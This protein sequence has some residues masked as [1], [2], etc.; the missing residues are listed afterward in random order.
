MVRGL[1]PCLLAASLAAAPLRAGASPG[2]QAEGECDRWAAI[3]AAEFGV[4]ER[5]LLA[6]TR[7]ETGRAGA[8]GVVAP[9]PWTV[10]AG[11]EGHWF[12]SARAAADFVRSAVARGE[13]QVDVG[14]FQLNTGW[15]GRAFASA[16]QMIEPSRN[17]RY[18][19]RFLANLHAEFGTWTQAAA[20][21]HSRT[22]HLGR[23]YLAKVSAALGEMG[24]A[25][26]NAPGRIQPLVAGA[27]ADAPP[28]VAPGAV[29]AAPGGVALGGLTGAAPAATLFP[30]R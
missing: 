17:A 30:G 20:A 4:P 26:R 1:L 16:D 23:T 3:A 15:H 28:R 18:A 22:P 5:L 21:F 25:P 27:L 24:E 6:I 29:K 12:A 13:A 14:C 19:A 10:N 8:S 11:G 2:P 9:W 7:V